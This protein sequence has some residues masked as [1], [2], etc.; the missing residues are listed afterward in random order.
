[1]IEQIAIACTGCTAIYLA[2]DH[3][4]GWRRWASVFGLCGQ[5]FWFYSALIA[6]QWGILLLT[7]FYTFAWWRGFRNNWLQAYRH[8]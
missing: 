1:M 6:Q 8:D 3:R 7:F 5:P 2:N 4:P